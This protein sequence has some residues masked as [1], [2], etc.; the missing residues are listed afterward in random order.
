MVRVRRAAGTGARGLSGG[1]LYHDLYRV[2]GSFESP[3]VD[4][5][6]VHMTSV[7]K[8]LE[9]LERSQS[10]RGGTSNDQIVRRVLER[11]SDAELDLLE[12]AAATVAQGREL[13][14]AESA[15]AEAYASAVARES[16]VERSNRG[17]QRQR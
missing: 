12:S 3:R 13:T 7:R 2:S 14:P 8:R 15:A 17:Q 11:V 10:V 4:A 16:V 5:K 1:G 9:T 6:G